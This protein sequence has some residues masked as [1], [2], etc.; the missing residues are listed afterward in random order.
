MFFAFTWGVFFYG[1]E[2]SVYKN[3]SIPKL[4]SS[5]KICQI[6]SIKR[7]HMSQNIYICIWC[8]ISDSIPSFSGLTAYSA[9]DNDSWILDQ[10]Q[11]PWKT[12]DRFCFLLQYFNFFQ[13]N[14]RSFLVEYPHYRR[15]VIRSIQTYGAKLKKCR[16]KPLELVQRTCLLGMKYMSKNAIEV[17]L[18][19][20]PIHIQLNYEA[21]LTASRQMILGHWSQT[22][23]PL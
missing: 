11:G 18:D 16:I 7:N 21:R 2:R 1:W 4:S 22:W 14:C 12:Y 10:F 13:V 23:L 3:D 6:R 15:S 9:Y 8:I 19:I 17:M 20:R 5:V